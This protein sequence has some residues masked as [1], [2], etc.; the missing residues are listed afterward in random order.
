MSRAIKVRRRAFLDRELRRA[1]RLMSALSIGT[2]LLALGTN[3]P[4]KGNP[5]IR[6][7]RGFSS[8]T[9]M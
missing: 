3:T 5:R 4:S 7:A 2:Q 9:Q 1:T 8:G 6:Q